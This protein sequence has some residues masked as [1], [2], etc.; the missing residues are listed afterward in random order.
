MKLLDFNQ[1]QRSPQEK[2]ETFDKKEALDINLARLNHLKSLN[3]NLA[4]KRVVDTGCGV[5]HLAQFFVQQDCDILGLEGR[6]ENIAELKKKYPG[7]KC[8]LADVEQDDLSKFGEFD[9]VFCY[10]LLYHTENP[11]LVI[12]KL[13]G[14]CQELILLETCITDYPEP[15]LRYIEETGTYSQALRGL[16][17]R[18]TPSLVVSLLKFNG[19]KHVY[20]PKYLPNHQDFEFKF[21]GDLSYQKNGHNIRQIFIATK[22]YL[23]AND[24]LIRVY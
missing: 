3:L 1:F 12:E 22:D 8:A 14:I 24:N 7:L 18:P 23:L 6:P 17:S 20:L 4:G 19:F 21:Q 13:S 9:V 16:G 5:G 11:A 15:L 2:T 10:G